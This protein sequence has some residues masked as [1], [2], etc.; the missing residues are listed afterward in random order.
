MAD[1]DRAVDR[2]I[3]VLVGL[4]I[5]SMV[6][7]VV[8]FGLYVSQGNFLECLK[9]VINLGL[10]GVCTYFVLRRNQIVLMYIAASSAKSLYYF[11]PYFGLQH[12]FIIFMYS[13]FLLELALV[14]VPVLILLIVNRERIKRLEKAPGL[15]KNILRLTAVAGAMGLA[16]YAVLF[17]GF[18]GDSAIYS[19]SLETLFYA[20]VVIAVFAVYAARVNSFIGLTVVNG[21]IFLICLLDY[22]SSTGIVENFPEQKILLLVNML[23][24]L[25]AFM[26]SLI[27]TLA[28]MVAIIFDPESLAKRFDNNLLAKM[29]SKDK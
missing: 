17:Y 13:L 26:P 28:G 16:V 24:L 8:L 2:L 25:F 10:L 9:L 23:A 3:M 20:S 1:A 21:A 15:L 14:F 7:R 5:V 29:F 18:R 19:D 4:L 12:P 22:E 6:L 27:A 11:T